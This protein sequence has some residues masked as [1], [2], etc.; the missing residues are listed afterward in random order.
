MGL[1]FTKFKYK[2]QNGTTWGPLGRAK[3]W[4]FKSQGVGSGSC[5]RHSR[6]RGFRVLGLIG[7]IGFI[8]FVG[9][10]VG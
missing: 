6:F 10:E 3:L 5:L 8:G 9:F 2:P 4:G 1:P 7:F